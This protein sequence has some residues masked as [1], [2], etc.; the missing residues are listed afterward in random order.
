MVLNFGGNQLFPTPGLYNDIGSNPERWHQDG[1]VI[2]NVVAGPI[3]ADSTLYTVTAGKVFY[4][5]KVMFTMG[6][7]GDGED[8]FQLKDGAAGSEKTT[9]GV[10]GNLEDT[11]YIYDYATP[12]F[13]TDSVYFNEFDDLNIASIYLYG[14]EEEA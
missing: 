2:K 6:L 7:T 10:V 3:T 14:W 1:S 12:L 4:V 5:T 8:R 13:F 11:T 9:I